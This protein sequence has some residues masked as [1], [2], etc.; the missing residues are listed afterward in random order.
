MEIGFFGNNILKCSQ[1]TVL[2]IFFNF[3]YIVLHKNNV[4]KFFKYKKKLLYWK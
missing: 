4:E 3:L 2:V 1:L